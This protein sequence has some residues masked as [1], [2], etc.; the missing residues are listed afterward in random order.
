M[1]VAI[2]LGLLCSNNNKLITFSEHPQLFHVYD[3]T[4]K[5]QVH[6]VRQMPWGSNTNFE[7]V[8]DLVLGMS[9]SQKI[10]KVYVF[11]DM[12][13][14]MAFGRN[15]STHFKMVRNRFKIAGIDMPQIVFWN[16]RGNTCD[17]P[18]CQDDTNV[19][20]LSGYSPALLSSILSGEKVT[21]LTVLMNILDSPRY[22]VVRKVL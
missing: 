8:M 13:F 12:Q 21:P 17:F 10:E 16:L 7:R 14:D 18:V 11:S 4:L 15:T 9:A 2:A 3:G 19:I 6:L 1:H 22:D 20:M 5:E